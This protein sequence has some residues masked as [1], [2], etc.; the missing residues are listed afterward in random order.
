MCSDIRAEVGTPVCQLFLAQGFGTAHQLAGHPAPRS[1]LAEAVLH[2]LHLHVVP[3]GEERA[4]DAA[5]VSHI[6]VPIRRP[7]PNTDRSEVARLAR[8]RMPLIDRVVGNAVEADLPVAPSL[9]PR[10]FGA[11]DVI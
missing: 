4:E 9:S 10:P 1:P 11:V 8:R 6:A 3:V 5:V 7:L 2:R